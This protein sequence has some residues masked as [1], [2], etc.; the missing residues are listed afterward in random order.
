[1]TKRIAVVMLSAVV[2]LTTGLGTLIASAGQNANRPSAKGEMKQSGKEA[3]QAG[4]SLG[5]NVKHGR[6]A[7]G[8][9]QF[10]KHTYRSGKHFG[11]GTAKGAKKGVKKTTSAVKKVVKP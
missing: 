8:G 6:I 5:T 9:K 2:F 7:R 10:G 1:M 11:K 4:K 3:K